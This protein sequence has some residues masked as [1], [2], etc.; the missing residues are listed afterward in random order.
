MTAMQPQNRQY[1]SIFDLPESPA[2]EVVE[3]KSFRNTLM[4]ALGYTAI[5]PIF[6][7]GVMQQQQFSTA[8][9][10]ADVA[11]VALAQSIA[12]S[13]RDY[14][15]NAISLIRLGGFPETA[16]GAGNGKTAEG[17]RLLEQNR[18]LYG[19]R[20]IDRGGRPLPNI[21][22]FRSLSSEQW[23]EAQLW[24]RRAMDE[25]SVD[26]AVEYRRLLSSRGLLLAVRA[27]DRS[28]RADYAVAFLSLEPIQQAVTAAMEGKSFD[29]A[30]LDKA[31]QYIVGFDNPGTQ[32]NFAA[33]LADG[34][35]ADF[36]QAGPEG[37]VIRTAGKRNESQI[38]AF[39]R[40]GDLGWTVVVSEP[41][42]RRDEVLRTSLATSGLFLLIAIFATLFVGA[43][44]ALPLT[45]SVNRLSEAVDRFGT[46]GS[47]KPIGKSL[48]KDGTTEI[49]ELG[50][51]FDRMVEAV[52]RSRRDLQRL[53]ATLE[54]Q[55]E[56][57][58]ETL[59]SRNAELQA[60]QALLVPISSQEAGSTRLHINS[61]IERFRILLDLKSLAFVPGVQKPSQES[62]ASPI[63]IAL[64]GDVFGW[65]R[66]AADDSLSA[67]RKASLMRLANSIAVV[68]ANEHLIGELAREHETLNTVFKSMTDAVIIIGR[69][70]KIVYANEYANR[71]LC[72]S[73]SAV[74]CMAIELVQSRWQPDK[75]ALSQNIFTSVG[76]TARLVERTASDRG[77]S[78]DLTPFEV[79]DLPGFPGKRTGWLMRDVTEAAAVEH[80]K[81]TL[82]SVVAHELKTPVT[83]MSLQTE[84][85]SRDLAAGRPVTPLSVSELRDETKRLGQLIDDL[86]DLSRIQGGAMKLFP[87]VV[88]VASLIDRAARLTKSR[89][90][91]RISR[92]IEPE[93]E[94]IM[95]DPDRIT[96]VF[97]NLFNN[98]A[99]YK[100]P[101]QDEALCD[102]FV[103][104]RTDGVQIVVR[105]FGRGIEASKL[106]LVFER[107]FQAD[108]S[109]TRSSGGTGLGLS[110][111]KGI[112]AAHKGTI[113]V[114]SIFGSLTEFTIK[115]P[116]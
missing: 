16:D 34:E 20:V 39:V 33:R 36:A 68:L 90:P 25:T 78:I 40:A 95:A 2:E 27:P 105:D 116:Y 87:R 56:E 1:P 24:A 96:Q 61:I 115:L 75:D 85:L 38:K 32:Y 5:V 106:D 101:S 102:V 4:S 73:Q 26:S 67:D 91:I 71:I 54:S 83:A 111:A 3:P 53:N 14:V 23:L 63:A 89:Y 76:T 46:G 93:A 48:E 82:L 59:R 42:S 113:R 66:I 86:L 18:N 72:P 15:N 84:T 37:R 81:D 51:A 114:N 104:A 70:G 98:A 6:L 80:M 62:S 99:R 30:I 22:D 92:K 7:L 100:K 74:G 12:T 65:L 50:R 47:D 10:Q 49:I 31:G 58:T 43:G 28:V 9:E 77:R 64:G 19:L 69:S 29:A 8:M 107:F 17:A 52:N 21:Q 13:A 88:Q 44:V 60:L 112:I 35:K 109:D 55:V 94:T 57:R 41:L 103:T 97:V 79:A 110:I 11:Q 108:M 45:R